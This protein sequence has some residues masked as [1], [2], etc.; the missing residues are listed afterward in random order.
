VDNLIAGME[1]EVK[2]KKEKQAMDALE[3][4]D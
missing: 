2:S 4:E 1:A 3:Q